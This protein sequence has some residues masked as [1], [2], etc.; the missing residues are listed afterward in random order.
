MR[1]G[2]SA[3]VR[4]TVGAFNF[5]RRVGFPST[6]EVLSIFATI[7]FLVV[8]V[9][10][11][12]SGESLSATLVFAGVVLVGPA[13][14]GEVL[15]SI[16]FLRK[17]HVLN[18]RRLMGLELI[19]LLPLA[20]TVPVSAA[21]GLLAGVHELWVD[22][23]LIGL[24]ASLP[25]RCLTM[26]AISSLR[27]WRKLVAAMITP[28]V[29]IR[30]YLGVTAAI[31]LG[32]SVATVLPRALIVLVVGLALS[33]VGVSWIIKTVETTGS[34]EIGDS[35]IGLFRAFLDHWLG[36]KPEALEERLDKLG[37]PG[38]IETKILSFSGRDSLPKASIIV[39][40]FHPGPYRDLGSAGLPSEL[41]H[42]V[43][44]YV[45]GVVHVPH[46]ISNHQLNIIS[47]ENIGKILSAT[48]NN[49]PSHHS[50]QTS[51]GMIREQVGE[52]K[53]AGQAFD[54]IAVLT[55]TLAPTEMEDL[56]LNVQEEIEREASK[57]GFE[58]LIIDAHNSISDQTSITPAEARS[59]V[60]AATKVLDVLNSSPRD[61]FK[62]GAAEDPL[63][64]FSLEDGIGPGGLSVSTVKNRERIVAYVTVDG[65]NMQTGFRE[66]VLESL[67]EIGISDGE[68]MTTD[69]HLVTGL[70]RSSLGYYPVGA[71]IDKGLLIR[72]ITTAVNRA[73]SSMEDSSAGFFKFSL[74][75]RVLGSDTFQAITSFVGRI[76][77]QIGRSFWWL[78]VSSVAS[79]LAILLLL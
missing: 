16:L 69:T 1:S 11:P 37:S 24:I 48:K 40:N 20:A 21:V 38:S 59:T 73:N 68:V 25:I 51:S 29:T 47:H 18:F 34:S 76:A 41:K 79:G 67:R 19:S 9:S 15:N 33:A 56:P 49:Y 64:E 8:I 39:S 44:H 50:I 62:I 75:L 12:A 13:V 22:G 63:N 14:G 5:I 17:D 77:R 54:N 52:A 43:A 30:A 28:L 10:L 45:G 2:P 23:F 70:V 71:H 55:I 65:N 42:S 31:A 61:Q 78:E 72:K 66:Q 36:S 6:P 32:P 26:V 60:E 57:R 35:P 27:A 3:G 4:D 74:Q 53:V 46:G 58:V 7:S